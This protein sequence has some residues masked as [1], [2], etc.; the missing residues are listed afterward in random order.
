VQLDFEPSKQVVVVEEE[1]DGDADV[2]GHNCIVQQAD[3]MKLA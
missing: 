3:R 2:A 1:G